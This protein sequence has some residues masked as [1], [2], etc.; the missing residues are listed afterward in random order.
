M[1]GGQRFIILMEAGNIVGVCP[2]SLD[3]YSGI[4][5]SMIAVIM[6]FTR[7][8]WGLSMNILVFYSNY[9]NVK[10]SKRDS[11]HV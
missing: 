2:L 10:L 7:Y 3:D 6:R 9:E 8:D 4:S 1:N 11:K 5:P